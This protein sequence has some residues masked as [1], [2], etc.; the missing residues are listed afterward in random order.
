MTPAPR[1][2]FPASFGS[3]Y[4]R[5]SVGQSGRQR[6]P[7]CRLSLSGQ[8]GEERPWLYRLSCPEHLGG[9]RTSLSLLSFPGQSGGLSYRLFSAGSGGLSPA[10]QPEH[11]SGL[12]AGLSADSP[13]GLFPSQSV[14]VAST[15]GMA[16]DSPRPGSS[17]CHLS[18]RGLSCCQSK[19]EICGLDVG[20]WVR[21]E[22][23]LPS[24]RRG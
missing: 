24:R 20:T 15:H 8:F 22:P 21:R 12:R 16:T 10:P 7:L 2:L 3:L 17:A 14:T 4:R 13:A 11:R 1:G 5:S 19:E 18:S 6:A 9:Q 23:G